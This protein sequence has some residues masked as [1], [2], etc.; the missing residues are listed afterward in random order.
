MT[1]YQGRHGWQGP[2]RPGPCL[3]FGF[4]YILIKNNQ[5][6]NLGWNIGPCLA[7]ILRGGPEYT[8][9]SLA[10]VRNNS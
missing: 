6:K 9:E 10:Y 5:S 3:D 4:E 1:L 7:Q 2:P 8:Q